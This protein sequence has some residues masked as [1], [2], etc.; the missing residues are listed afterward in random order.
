V[1]VCGLGIEQGSV[2]TRYADSINIATK[3]EEG[4]LFFLSL[5]LYLCR[6][7]C[8]LLA[9][10]TLLPRVQNTFIQLL[11]FSLS[12]LLLLLLLLLTECREFGSPRPQRGNRPLRG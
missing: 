2:G 3:P 8:M 4:L 6:R 7:A 5:S 10:L 9:L 1:R 11:F 12:L